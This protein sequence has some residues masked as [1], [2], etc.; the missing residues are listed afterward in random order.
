MSAG[1][2]QVIPYV[3]SVADSRWSIPDHTMSYVWDKMVDEQR[4]EHLFWSGGIRSE[5]DFISFLREPG[6]YP[7]LVFDAEIWEA[8]AIAW[9]NGIE[10]NHAL[11]HFCCL[12]K[13]RLACCKM[14]LDYWRSIKA[15]DG[16]PLFS[17]LLGVT[18]ETNELAIRVSKMLGF[19]RVG[20]IPKLCPMAYLNRTVGGVITY[21]DCE[22]E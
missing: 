3:F 19:Q 21:M 1:R 10:M 17:V 4:V 8:K 22:G 6:N 20:I 14:G 18:P 7:I 11:V 9:L 16:K 2:Y 13:F 15:I 5:I 12:G